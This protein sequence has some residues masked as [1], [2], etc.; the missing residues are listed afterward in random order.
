MYKL[1][2][3]WGIELVGIHPTR[4]R[5]CGGVLGDRKTGCAKT[6]VSRKDVT[7]R[8][9]ER[10]DWGTVS[11]R[12]TRFGCS[13]IGSRLLPSWFYST[14]LIALGFVAHLQLLRL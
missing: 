7:G 14:E 6:G 11:T 12:S 8:C 1:Q 5:N 4:E 3:R 9:R 13:R 10:G 2:L